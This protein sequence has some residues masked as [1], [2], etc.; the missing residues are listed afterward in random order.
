MN[1]GVV[2]QLV[3]S[4]SVACLLTSPA[5]AFQARSSAAGGPAVK[6]CS[7][8]TKDLVLP[9]AENPK[10]LDLIPPEEEAMANG[11]A[12]CEYGIVR[13]QLYAPRS[14][15]VR[16]APKDYQPLPG[17]GELAYFRNNRNQYAELMVWQGDRYFTLQV[18]VPSGSTADAIKPK[19]V[20]LANAIITRIK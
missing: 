1:G 11:G 13:L 19:T 2:R 3:A 16:T 4:L 18:S 14:G 5:F 7:I 6:A 10:L 8:L 15:A 17:V 20:T 9:F 12:A